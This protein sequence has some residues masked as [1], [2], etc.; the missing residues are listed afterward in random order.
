VLRPFTFQKSSSG[1]DGGGGHLGELADLDLAGKRSQAGKRS[2]CRL[3][4]H[5]SFTE[6]HQIN[7][8]TEN[9]VFQMPVVAMLKVF[10]FMC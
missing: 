2:H 9:V 1:T 4:V 8:T 7:T 5:L 10:A 3:F 6:F